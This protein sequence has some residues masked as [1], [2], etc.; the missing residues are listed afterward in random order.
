M[1]YKVDFTGYKQEQVLLAIWNASFTCAFYQTWGRHTRPPDQPTLQECSECLKRN[2]YVDY[3]HGRVI[4]INFDTFPILDG[5][6]YDRDVGAGSLSNVLAQMS[7]SSALVKKNRFK[8]PHPLDAEPTSMDIPINYPVS[9]EI[10]KYIIYT[11]GR[12]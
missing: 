9:D 1:C 8:T 7:G 12:N 2:S 5:R 4:K 3:L 6:L 11:F 10:D